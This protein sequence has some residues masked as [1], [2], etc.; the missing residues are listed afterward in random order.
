MPSRGLVRVIFRGVSYII[1]QPEKGAVYFVNVGSPL[2]AYDDDRFFDCERGRLY[3]C[4]F[5]IAP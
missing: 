5:T 3:V 2:L 1:V 4:G